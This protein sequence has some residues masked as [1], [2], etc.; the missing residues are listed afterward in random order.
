M[1]PDNSASLDIDTD[2][3][4]ARL[5]LSGRLDAEHCA[6]LWPRARA[7]MTQGAV[8]DT[9][10]VDYC[11]GTGAA[12]LFDLIQRGGTVEG[13]PERFAPL[14]AEL[15][16]DHPLIIPRRPP[17][18]GVIA[19]LGRVVAEVTLE[20]RAAIVFIGEASAAFASVMRRPRELRLGETLRVATSA[21]A[22]ALP[23][24]ALIAFL[25]GVIL[26][27][28]SAVPMRQFG[29]ELFVANLVG[30][31]LVRELAPLMTAVLLAGRTGAAFAAEIGTMKVN[32][33]IDALVT[34]GLD[35][36]RFLVLPRLIA[37]ACTMPLLTLFAELIGMFG[38]ALVLI[39]F[40][41][42]MATSASQIIDFVDM[43]DYLTGLFKSFVFGL[44]I[45]GIGCMRGLQTGS[46]ARA[47]GAAATSADVR[48]IVML[49][50]ADGLFAVAFYYLDW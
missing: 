35:P 9:S 32:Q 34:M 21:G 38:A 8:V 2:S 33:E 27:F 22:D 5:R 20:A 28:Q 14:L 50:V 16:P 25:L 1:T 47:V 23:I 18:P 15:E 13:L 10:A 11:D 17:P 44:G 26:S 31:S 36:M 37:V 7:A 19:T 12:L 30:L 48:A 6:D 4:P 24:V 45:A 46:G 3:T 49:V 29:A 39:G 42:P 40:G 41:I 43:S